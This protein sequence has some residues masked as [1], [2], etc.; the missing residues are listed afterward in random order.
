M[1]LKFLFLL[2]ISVTYVYCFRRV[3]LLITL[4]NGD[5]N[6]LCFYGTK[7]TKKLC[8]GREK[9]G[10][11]LNISQLW[12]PEWDYTGWY[13]FVMLPSE[14]IFLFFFFLFARFLEICSVVCSRQYSKIVVISKVPLPNYRPDLDDKR[15]QREVFN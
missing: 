6:L 3:R 4:I 11:I 13:I 9:I 1:N 8:Q 7:K 12:L 14:Y 2:L 5:L 10:V 15:P